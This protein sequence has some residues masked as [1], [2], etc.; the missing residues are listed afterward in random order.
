MSKS[1]LVDQFSRKPSL[2]KFAIFT[3][4]FGIILRFWFF[5]LPSFSGDEAEYAS[6]AVQTLRGTLDLI[7][8]RNIHVALDNTFLPT[9]QHAHGPL[10]FLIAIPMV[11][12]QPREFF[13]RLVFV[14]VGSITL[15][16]SFLILK[17]LR[18]FYV[19]SVFA[20]IFGTSVYAI[21]WSQ[22]AMYQ[23]LSIA[24][25]IF[26]FLSIIFFSKKPSR[27]TLNLLFLSPAVGLLVFP[28]FALFLPAIIWAV[29][30]K[31]NYLKI[32]DL[33]IA[34]GVFL[35]IAGTYYFPWVIYSII[36]GN[37]N[38]GFNH[39]LKAKL[40]ANVD[41]IRNLE[42]FWGNFFSFPG[43]YAIWPFAALSILIIKK[44]NYVK[45]ILLT[46]VLATSVYI[47]RAYTPYFY[48]VSIFAL[49]CILASELIARQKQT[50]YVILI[51]IVILNLNSVLSLLKGKHNPLIFGEKEQQIDRAKE[52]GS[53]AKRCIVSDEETFIST[54]PTGKS[55]YYFGRQ[56][57]AYYDGSEVIPKI[58]E[59]LEGDANN[60]KLIHYRKKDLDGGLEEK[61]KKNAL[62]VIQYNS[63]VV[64]LFKKCD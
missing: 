2:E 35:V 53:L 39:L 46:T 61:L 42:G 58:E 24:A 23:S 11:I 57:T 12:F 26:I 54:Y 14:V 27:K 22:T 25:S 38:V 7:L 44:V 20:I 13:I 32:T 43:V 5:W 51:L 3:I 55:A 45:Y 1:T 63:D 49:L 21:W 36:N 15:V 52:V 4:F 64:L 37:Q 8:G 62:N 19:A 50:G 59:F 18:N 30:D 40:A 56:S 33:L 47:F 31:R 48:F 28:D 29:Y 6:K 41:I 17:K 60:I 16:L 34:G 9:L 10:E